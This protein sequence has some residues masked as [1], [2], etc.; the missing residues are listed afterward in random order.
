MKNSYTRNSLISASI[1][2]AGISED[3]IGKVSGAKSVGE[4]GG[5]RQTVVI[6]GSI[7][8]A[9]L[10]NVRSG[11][12]KGA[13]LVGDVV[14]SV[15]QSAGSEEGQTIVTVE[16][17]QSISAQKKTDEWATAHEVVK[18]A[19]IAKEP[20][21]KALAEVAYTKLSAKGKDRKTVIAYFVEKIGLTQAGASTYFQNCKNAA[22][23]E[24]GEVEQA[25][26]EAEVAAS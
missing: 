7:E 16:F 5:V 4:E 19:A 22:A 24:G 3:S 21:K 15:S 14:S 1:I 10:R 2:A 9:A 8:T 12:K 18:A 23:G 25:A 11:I 6:T 20:S 17:A 26:P 13:K